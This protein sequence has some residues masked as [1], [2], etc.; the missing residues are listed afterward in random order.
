VTRLRAAIETGSFRTRERALVRIRDGGSTRYGFFFGMGVIAS[1]V[2]R[3]NQGR[4]SGPLA[5]QARSLWAML[6]GLRSTAGTATQAMK[7][8][9]VDFIEKPVKSTHLFE[10]IQTALDSDSPSS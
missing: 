8:G 6:T 4:K 2:E 9:A 7:S 3:W 5:N 1:V 10:R